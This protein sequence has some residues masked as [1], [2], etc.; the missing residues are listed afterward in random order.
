MVLEELKQRITVANNESMRL[1]TLR[2][3]SIGRR[4]ALIKQVEGM[5]NAYNSRYGT[6]LSSTDARGITAELEKVSAEKEKEVEHIEAVLRA[7]NNG[8]YATANQLCGVNS[9]EISNGDTPNFS[10]SQNLTPH[11]PNMT[12]VEI[13]NG[14]TPNFSSSQNLSSQVGVSNSVEISNGDTPNFSSSQNLTPPSGQPNSS[15]ILSGV[16]IVSSPVASSVGVGTIPQSVAS[17]SGLGLPPI[18]SG[19]G[20]AVATPP[21]T[22][23]GSNSSHFGE[24]IPNAAPQKNKGMSSLID[25]ALAGFT[26]LG[27]PPTI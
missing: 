5:L 25:D 22:V 26:S 23:S 11:V 16:G 6:N 13:S 10:S 7:I 15:G 19:L 8:D 27:V 14:D 1:N 21:T 9:V 3:Q 17:P 4:D 20:N 18:A 2:Q 24:G 12:S